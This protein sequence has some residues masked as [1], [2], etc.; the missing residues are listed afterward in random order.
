MRQ[1][2]AVMGAS[3]GG[4]LAFQ[5]GVTFPDF[6]RGLVPVVSAP[7]TPAPA[8]Q[9]VAETI[10]RFWE[11]PNWRGGRYAEAGGI[12]DTMRAIWADTL[13]LY[14]AEAVLAARFPDPVA[15]EA[16]LRRMAEAG[17]GFDANS[18]VTL[19]LAA[20]HFDVTH[21]LGKI[22]ARPLFA[23]ARTDAVFPCSLA[24]D[25]LRDLAGA[26]VQASYFELDTAFG[27]LAFREDQEQL[28]TPIRTFLASLNGR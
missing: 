15:C 20:S 3:Y 14:G 12:A 16:A 9:Q 8:L 6:M 24:P 27:H 28:D 18:F 5:W 7:R 17:A 25:I 11:D 4:I 10:A 2:T 23:L 21:C 26:G 22:R 1:L 13:R 19:G